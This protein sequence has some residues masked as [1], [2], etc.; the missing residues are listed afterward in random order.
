MITPMIENRSKDQPKQLRVSNK[1]L[2]AGWLSF[3]LIGLA[4]CQN[5]TLVAT[6]PVAEIATAAENSDAAVTQDQ[7]AESA[8]SNSKGVLNTASDLLGKAKSHSG[9]ATNWIKDRLGEATNVGSSSA[10]ETLDWANQTFQ[11]LKQQGLTTASSTSEW[12]NEDWNKMGAWEYK[13]IQLDSNLPKTQ[14]T[15]NELGADRWECFHVSVSAEQVQTFYF[16]KPARS[17]LNNIPFKDMMKLVPLLDDG[18]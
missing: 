12:V 3:H 13:I 11:S 17:Y 14:K 4:G 8:E 18:Q 15:L 2:V 16:K 1:M 7:Q 6:A 9:N 5:E 10:Q